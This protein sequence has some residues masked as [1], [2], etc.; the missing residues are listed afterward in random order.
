MQEA[1]QMIAKTLGTEFSSVLELVPEERLLR[2]WAGVGWKD[3]LI[4]RTMI[5][6]AAGWIIVRF[7]YRSITSTPGRTARRI[8][9]AVARWS[10][11]PAPDAA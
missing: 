2:L 6:A 10:A 3:G 4:G 7:T 5:S 11:F 8:Q 1:A 9:N